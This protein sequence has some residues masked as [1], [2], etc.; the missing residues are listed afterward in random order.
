MC[1]VQIDENSI[2]IVYRG[3]DIK[4][5]YANEWADQPELVFEIAQAIADSKGGPTHLARTLGVDLDDR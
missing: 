3:R 2:A 5:W 1:D 4:R